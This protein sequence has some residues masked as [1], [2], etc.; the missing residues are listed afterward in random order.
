MTDPEANE[1]GSTCSREKRKYVEEINEFT[2]K[3]QGTVVGGKIKEAR[4]RGCAQMEDKTQRRA[5]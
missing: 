3:T 2:Y 1:R 4:N 5:M